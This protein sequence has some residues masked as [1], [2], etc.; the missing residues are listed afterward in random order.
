SSPEAAGCLPFLSVHDAAG[1]GGPFLPGSP[2]ALRAQEHGQSHVARH[3]GGRVGQLRRLLDLDTRYRVELAHG[4]LL[5][6]FC[7]G[8]QQPQQSGA[9]ADSARNIAGCRSAEQQPSGAD[10]RLQSFEEQLRWVLD[11]VH[12]LCG[13]VCTCCGFLAFSRP[14]LCA[15]SGQLVWRRLLGF[16]HQHV[17]AEVRARFVR[18]DSLGEP[19]ARP[20]V[21]CTAA[22]SK[23]L[24]DGGE[25]PVHNISARYLSRAV[26]V[27]M[28]DSSMS[29]IK[30]LDP[31]VRRYTCGFAVAELKPAG[32]PE[33]QPLRLRAPGRGPGPS[34]LRTAPEAPCRHNSQA[35]VRLGA[36]APTLRAN[37]TPT[38]AAYFAD[39]Y[40]ALEAAR[41]EIFICDWWLTPELHLKRPDRRTG[42]SLMNMM[43]KAASQAQHLHT[44]PPEPP[45]QRRPIV[46]APREAAN[47]RSAPGLLLRHRPV[48]GPLGHSATPL[49]TKATL[50]GHPTVGQSATLTLSTPLSRPSRWFRRCRRG[51]F[52]DG[53]NVERFRRRQRDS[54]HGGLQR[55]RRLRGTPPDSALLSNRWTIR[56]P[57]APAKTKRRGLMRF[58]SVAA[59]AGSGILFAAASSSDGRVNG[60]RIFSSERTGQRQPVSW[61]RAE[62]A[63][64]ASGIRRR[65]GVEYQ[66]GRQPRWHVMATASCKSD[67]SRLAGLQPLARRNRADAHRSRR[68]AAAQAVG[69]AG[70]DQGLRR[71]SEDF[72]GI[73]LAVEARN[74][75]LW[76]GLDYVNWSLRAIQLA[77]PNRRACVDRNEVPECRGERTWPAQSATTRPAIWPGTSSSAGISQFRDRNLSTVRYP[78]LIPKASPLSMQ[79]LRKPLRGRLKPL[80]SLPAAAAASFRRRKAVCVG[81]KQRKRQTDYRLDGWTPAVGRPADNSGLSRLLPRLYNQCEHPR[82]VAPWSPALASEPQGAVITEGHVRAIDSAECLYIESQFFISNPTAIALPPRAPNHG[83]GRLPNRILRAHRGR[84]AV[85]PSTCCCHCGRSS[86][87]ALV[88]RPACDGQEDF[89]PDLSPCAEAPVLP[90]GAELNRAGSSDHT[91]YLRYLLALRTVGRMP[92]GRLSNQTN[93]VHSKPAHS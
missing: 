86:R 52:H 8:E 39:V 76:K 77:Q 20:T 51:G 35:A 49:T 15:W 67:D 2:V 47:C 92:S 91:R 45:V 9:R 10:S 69:C 40:E 61:R 1:H 58:L 38:D 74:I 32:V 3:L 27:F 88:E 42:T 11:R 16:V 84:P 46:D 41:Q 71:T 29:V 85:P 17:E 14:E 87:S 83:G 81:R 44:A 6:E 57:L 60:G 93:L 90:A 26:E 78:M 80:Q 64:A 21:T 34:L 7:E 13:T 19:A 48:L 37:G 31:S 43:L 66:A 89:A 75:Q 59:A 30:G 36:I 70:G 62:A 18:G 65:F 25:E 56:R 24:L 28:I 68:S 54:R 53:R 55:H 63:A 50:I 23:R 5:H 12:S 33:L 73:A 4:L 22:R 72:C 82:S 79:P